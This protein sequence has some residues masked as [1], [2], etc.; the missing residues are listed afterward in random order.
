MG[1]KKIYWRPEMSVI[2]LNE[3]EDIICSSNGDND[4][5]SG[6]MPLDLGF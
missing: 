1:E 3:Q 5:D 6:L 4:A 2:F